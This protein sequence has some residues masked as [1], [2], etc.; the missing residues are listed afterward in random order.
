MPTLHEGPTHNTRSVSRVTEN[1]CTESTNSAQPY[2]SALD[3]C[4]AKSLAPTG[5]FPDSYE[6]NR[7]FKISTGHVPTNDNV[8]QNM[9][10]L[11]LVNTK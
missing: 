10:N 9:L 7:N 4:W 6:P 2:D 8:N 1:A 5:N 11:F 3:Q